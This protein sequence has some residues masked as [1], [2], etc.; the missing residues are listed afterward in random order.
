MKPLG[1]KKPTRPNLHSAALTRPRRALAAREE[2]RG[3]P[4]VD[5]G[6]CH[7]P[8]LARF[9]TRSTHSF[10]TL[11][12]S[13]SSSSSSSWSLVCI[14]RGHFLLL[15]FCSGARS[16][17]WPFILSRTLSSHAPSVPRT[18]NRSFFVVVLGA[19]CRSRTTENCLAVHVVT[20]S[21]PLVHSRR[22]APRNML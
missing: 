21:G 1:V 16:P 14:W 6:V 8:L 12:S 19:S 15:P 2:S 10:S 18:R 22:S 11:S 20:A 13:S 3:T 5:C 4:G 7:C 9:H 17:C